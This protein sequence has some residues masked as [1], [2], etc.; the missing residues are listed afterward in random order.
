MTGNRFIARQA[1]CPHMAAIGSLMLRGLRPGRILS[2]A[3]S[4]SSP[5]PRSRGFD[6]PGALEMRSLEAW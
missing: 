4:E 5:H 3:T 1:I 2:F 6:E